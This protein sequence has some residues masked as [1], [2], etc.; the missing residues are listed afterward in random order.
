MK[1]STR[2]LTGLLLLVVTGLLISNIILKKEYDKIDKSDVYW[3]Y[4]KISE[5]SF[6]YLKINGGN[7]TNVTFEQSP[8]SS[9]RILRAWQRY[10]NG[11]IIPVI[12]DDTL[13]INFPP[14]DKNPYEKFWM[15]RTTLVRIFCPNLLAVDCYNTNL[16]LFKLKQKNIAATVYGRSKFEVESLIRDIDSVKIIQ[17][18]TSEVVFEMSPDFKPGNKNAVPVAKKVTNVEESPENIKN[19]EAM[20]ILFV[21]ADIKGNSLFDIGH[22][23]VG[24]LQLN[25]ADS[26]GIIFSGGALK[27]YKQ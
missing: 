12:K 24:T 2:I 26:S 18:D 16:N 14:E 15:Q 9:V 10:H 3:T 17:A 25:I 6:K 1:L 13:F 22:A 23:Q 21:N 8:H 20:N 7:I 4:T 27:K 19:P 5:Q 11:S